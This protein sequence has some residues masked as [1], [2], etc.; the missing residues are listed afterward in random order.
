MAQLQFVIQRFN[1]GWYEDY[2]TRLAMEDMTVIKQELGVSYRLN[3]SFFAV[4]DGHGGIDCV[5]YIAEYMVENLRTLIL[6]S[7]VIFDD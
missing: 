2:G 6:R 3:F 1:C 4:Y 7:E 5:K